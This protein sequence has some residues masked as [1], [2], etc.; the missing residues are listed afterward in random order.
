MPLYLVVK[1]LKRYYKLIGFFAFLVVFLPAR[2]QEAEWSNPEKFRT[3]TAFTRILGQNGHGIYVLRSKSR[4]MGRKVYVQMYKENMGQVFSKLL[5]G[6]KK[7]NFENAFVYNDGLRLL[8]S[9]YNRSTHSIDLSAQ[10]YNLEAEP[11]GEPVHITSAPQRDY[12]DEGD[13]IVKASLDQTKILCFHTE[14]SAEKNTIIEIVVLEAAS[15]QEKSRKKIELPHGYGDFTVLNAEVANNGNAY[16]IFRVEDDTRKKNDF[17]RYG[18]FL[19]AYNAAGNLLQDFYLNNNDTYLSRPHLTVDYLANKIIVSGLY[20]LID[21]GFSKGILDFGLDLHTHSVLYHSFLPYPKDFVGEVIGMRQAENGE[22]LK[23]YYIR[24]VIPHSD[25]GYFLLAEEYYISSQSYTFTINGMVQVG[26]RDIYNFG[27]VIVLS[28]TKTGEIEWGKV[29]NKNQTSSLDL[30][31]Y[32]SFYAMSQ[33]NKINIFYNDENRGN[34]E[35]TLYTLDANG[36][37]DSRLLFKN[38]T[39]SISVIPR[40]GQQLDAITVLFPAAKDRKFAFLKLLVN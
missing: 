28:V 16:F 21:A 40:E 22:E 1:L 29:I 17:E 38:Q 8:K 12:S 26:N 30:G 18:Y 39:S 3:K 4:F 20:S 19:Y 15:L 7:A 32:S 2:A 23:D 24:K 5:P 14:I 9:S 11:V 27:K 33:R 34:S 6:M 36:E 31:Y 13:Y 10:A 37:L 25:S 35:V